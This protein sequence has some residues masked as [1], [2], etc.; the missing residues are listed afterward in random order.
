MQLLTVKNVRDRLRCTRQHVYNLI[1]RGDIET[2][3][4]GKF[5]RVSETALLEYI[6]NHTV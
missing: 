6:N 2:V 1:R 3:K 4:D 5:I